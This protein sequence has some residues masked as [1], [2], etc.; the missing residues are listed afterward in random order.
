MIGR[1]TFSKRLEG[2]KAIGP[3]R[4][5]VL[6]Y[7]AVQNGTLRANKRV[8]EEGERLDTISF[9]VYG[10]PTFWWVIAGASGIGWGLQVPPGTLLRIPN[11]IS[12]ALTILS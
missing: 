3:A 7:R 10:S 1:Y 6:L 4:A 9:E 11:S 12:D 2:G 8:L 5:S